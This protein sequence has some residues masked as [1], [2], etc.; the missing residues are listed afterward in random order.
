MDGFRWGFLGEGQPCI[1]LYF[2]GWTLDTSGKF[3][4]A[5]IGVVIL[6]ILTEGVSKFRHD[7]ANKGRREVMTL[8]G[9]RKFR[10]AQT[11]L[12]GLHAVA[13]YFLMLAA[14]TFVIDLCYSWFGHRVCSVWWRHLQS[15][16][17]PLLCVPRGR[18]Q[19]TRS[20]L[21]KQQQVA[22][23]SNSGRFF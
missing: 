9:A 3:A 23:N 7:L 2:P 16:G 13:G 22:H 17:E 15:R 8:Q 12:H 10:V 18:S 21:W 4:G 20:K 14:M 6:G 19:R 11:G 5:M 1:N